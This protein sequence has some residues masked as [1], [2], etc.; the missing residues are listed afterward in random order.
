[1]RHHLASIVIAQFLLLGGL[2]CPSRADDSPDTRAPTERTETERI[3][4]LTQMRS[5]LTA[6]AEIEEG[7]G[8]GDL[9]QVARVAAA[10][11]R[12]ATTTLVRPPTLAAKESDAWKAMIASM[13]TGFDQI[14]DE[15]TARAPAMQINKALAET[16]HNCIACHQTYR[17]TVDGR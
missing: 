5:F 15:A 16:M 2:S 13:R 10:R 8:S 11:G 1:M 17:I 7:L 9:D 6:V 4:V 14:A 3:F 12:K